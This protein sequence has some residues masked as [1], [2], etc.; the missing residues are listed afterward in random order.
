VV[1]H[2]DYAHDLPHVQAH[3]RELNQVWTNL[4]E[5]AIDAVGAHGTIAIRTS[6]RDGYVLAEIEDD[7][8]GMPPE[9]MARVFDPFF[10]TKAPGKGTGL[11]LNISHNIVV[12][13]HKGRIEVASQ[14]G[15][16]T[17]RVFLPTAVPARS[18]P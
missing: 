8:P 17:F 11:G 5:N 9:A 1:V 13:E 3:G 18:A 6:A 7:G 14:P 10:T 16:T 2:R 4:I 12:A 15:R